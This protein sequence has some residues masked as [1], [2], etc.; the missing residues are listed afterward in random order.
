MD[1][2]TSSDLWVS[3]EEVPGAVATGKTAKVAYDIGAA[4][5]TVL[6]NLISTKLTRRIRK[7]RPCVVW[8]TGVCRLYGDEPGI[9]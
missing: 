3:G 2:T 6:R 9:L 8:K 1:I 5:G 7:F 4:E